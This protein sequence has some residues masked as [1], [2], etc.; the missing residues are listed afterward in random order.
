MSFF[1]NPGMLAPAR[2]TRIDLAKGG[3]ILACSDALGEVTRCIGDWLADAAVAIDALTEGPQ[4]LVGSSMGG[5]ISLLLARAF[6]GVVSEPARKW[7]P[8]IYGIGAQIL[9]RLGVG[10][11]RLMSK[12]L[13]IPSMTGFSLEVCGY[14]EAASRQS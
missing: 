14:L 2:V 13:K 10:R 8:K 7:D 4:V 1:D 5:W 3:F 9:K 12:P 11:M 6:P